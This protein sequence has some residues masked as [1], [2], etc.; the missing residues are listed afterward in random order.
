ML[1]KVDIA[2]GRRGTEQTLQIMRSMIDEYKSCP[3]IRDLSLKIIKQ[4][5]AK[6]HKLLKLKALWRWVKR[7]VDYVAD[8]S[9]VEYIQAPRRLIESGAGDCDDLAVLIASMAESVGIS[10]KL[11]AV[12]LKGRDAFSHVFPVVRYGHYEIAADAT[13]NRSMGWQ[14]TNTVDSIYL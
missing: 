1:T 3:F 5:S 12:K 14:P 13:V 8:V 6:N 2:P 11:K 9:G 4:A 10:T 7:N